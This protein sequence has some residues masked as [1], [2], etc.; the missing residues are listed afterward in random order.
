MSFGPPVS[1][2]KQRG[3]GLT[4]SPPDALIPAG[5]RPDFNPP[6]RCFVSF[7]LSSDGKMNFSR[8][9]FLPSSVLRSEGGG[10]LDF[11]GQDLPEPPL[12]LLHVG[13]LGSGQVEAAPSFLSVH[14]SQR[15]EH[16]KHR[17]AE[18]NPGWFKK[19]VFQDSREC[20]HGNQWKSNHA[21]HL[22]AQMEEGSVDS[23]VVFSGRGLEVNSP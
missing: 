12:Q 2:Q 6:C 13:R 4:Q 21:S 19:K 14:A 10:R 18:V 20:W 5:R 7:V 11:G 17:R 9:T 1:P 23:F 22:L 8:P 16:L 15:S 3:A